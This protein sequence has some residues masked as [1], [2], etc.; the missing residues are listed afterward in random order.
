M[1]AYLLKSLD[2]ANAFPKADTMYLVKCGEDAAKICMFQRDS[3]ITT[4]GSGKKEFTVKLGRYSPHDLEAVALVESLRAAGYLVS[5]E[6]VP[7]DGQ[8]RM[9]VGLS[10][11]AEAEGDAKILVEGIVHTDAQFVRVRAAA[12]K[13][14]TLV[15][16]MAEIAR[17]GGT[18]H[19]LV[20]DKVIRCLGWLHDDSPYTDDTKP[21]MQHNGKYPVMTS[22]YESANVDGLYFAGQLAHGKDFRRA[23]GG[24][25]HGFRYTARA[26]FNVLE[27]KYHDQSWPGETF[28]AVQAWDG[29]GIGLG[30]LG[31]N[32]GDWGMGQEGCP[33]PQVMD[34]TYEKLI[35]NIFSRI[36]TASGIYQMVGVLGQ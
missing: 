9:G 33:K 2:G 29:K 36:N 17:R 32:K 25:I 10:G 27:H 14:Q 11:A 7:N 16:V 34:S 35:D 21:W 28:P 6:R 20:Y 12:L 15:N 5:T 23:A 13:N 8:S 30:P 18:P 26:L 19:P 22:E 31:C 4:P 3:I 24:F 1:D